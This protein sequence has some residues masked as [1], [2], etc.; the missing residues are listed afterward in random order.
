MAAWTDWRSLRAESEVNE[1]RVTA[2]RRVMQAEQ[3]LYDLLE[4]RGL[5]GAKLEAAFEAMQQ[6]GSAAEQ[7]VETFLSIVMGYVTALGG[8][9]EVRA[10]FP[11]ETVTLLTSE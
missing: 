11:N 5:S 10:V 8:Q 6:A 4:K 2:Y 7:D 9:L 1:D 3:V